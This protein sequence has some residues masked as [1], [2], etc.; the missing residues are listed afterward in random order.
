MFVPTNKE[1]AM[2]DFQ[3]I[4]HEQLEQV[5]GGWGISVGPIKW[6]PDVSPRVNSPGG[7]GPTT[8]GPNSPIIYNGCP[9][10]A[11]TNTVGG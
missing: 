10:P 1:T 7:S 8:T 6:G 3:E 4:D 9:A 2:H 11:P 5:S